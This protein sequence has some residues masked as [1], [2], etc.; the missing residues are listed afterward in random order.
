MRWDSG[1]ALRAE[2]LPNDPHAQNG[3][4]KTSKRN[5]RR[6]ATKTSKRNIRRGAQTKP[7]TA[8]RTKI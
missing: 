5:I 7:T 2:I 4:T 3:A 6:G 8:G 1:V